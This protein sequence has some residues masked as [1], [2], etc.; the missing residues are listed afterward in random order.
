MDDR[1]R[2]RILVFYFAGFLNLVLGFYVLLNGRTLVDQGMWYL[3]LAFFFGFAAVDFWFARN[4]RRNWAK[5]Q[6][7]L[8]AGQGKAEGNPV[9]RES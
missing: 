6:A 7:R 9:K 8:A 4:L 2:K 3:L 1:I 5:A